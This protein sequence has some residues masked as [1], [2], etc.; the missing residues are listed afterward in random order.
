M[1]KHN[2]SRN[3]ISQS[4]IK[5][6]RVDVSQNDLP[7]ISSTKKKQRQDKK[8]DDQSSFNIQEQ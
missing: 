6:S 7:Q 5:Q 2:N 4:D 1:F 8:K 3:Y